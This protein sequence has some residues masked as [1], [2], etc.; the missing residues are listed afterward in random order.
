MKRF[1]AAAAALLLA[2]SSSFASWDYF[3]PEDAGEGVAKVGMEHHVPREK[4]SNFGLMLG[5]AYTILPGLEASLILPMPMSAKVNDVS[6][7]NVGGLACPILGVRYWVPLVGI[8]F[9]GDFVLPIDT[10]DEK[11]NP[12]ADPDFDM[13]IGMQYLRTFTPLLKIASEIRLENLVTDGADVDMGLGSEMNINLGL[14][15]P[16]FGIEW[17]NLFE[18]GGK[19]TFHLI[20]GAAVPIGKITIDASLD[21]GIAGYKTTT[22]NMTTLQFES[23]NETPMTIRAN[24]SYGF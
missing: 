20:M 11:K 12:E 22:I 6:A 24:V 4:S 5:A 15:T 18:N 19:T 10:R 13:T 3:P 9:F 14:L 8:G 23:E 17:D 2:A 7:K 21:L 1:S 16:F